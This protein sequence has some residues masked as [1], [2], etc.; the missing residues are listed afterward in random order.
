MILGNKCDLKQGAYKE[1][2]RVNFLEAKVYKSCAMYSSVVPYD[3]MTLYMYSSC[4]L[5]LAISILIL[6]LSVSESVCDMRAGGHG[7][8]Y[9]PC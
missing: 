5:L 1:N 7:K 6:H 9:E 4:Q 3:M 2:E 8:P